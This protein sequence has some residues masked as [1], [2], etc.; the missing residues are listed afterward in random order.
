[1]RGRE[2]PRSRGRPRRRRARE[3]R[4]GAPAHPRRTRSTAGGGCTEGAAGRPS[5]APPWAPPLLRDRGRRRR[6]GGRR[7][8]R[9]ALEVIQR[10]VELQ[11]FLLRARL[12]LGRLVVGPG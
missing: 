8:D 12:A 9:Q 1:M 10:R 11:V 2:A 6:G 3:R 4:G 7:G 5:V